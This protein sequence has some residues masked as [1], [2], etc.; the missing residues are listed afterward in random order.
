[1][2]QYLPVVTMA[3]LAVVFAAVSAFY[4]LRAERERVTNET[5]EQSRIVMTLVDTQLQR[6]LS[7]LTVLSSSIYFENKKWDEFYGRMQRLLAANSLWESLVIVDAQA[8]REIFDLRRPFGAQL[9]LGE[10]HER[11]VTR[12][13]S[14]GAPGPA[15]TRL[16]TVTSSLPTR[17]ET[18]ARTW[19]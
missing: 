13:V 3:V 1:M 11:Y 9:S 16:P 19:V 14:T 8:R 5:I 7:A 18:G 2:G 10:M 4:L 17:P 6:H 15:E 12:V